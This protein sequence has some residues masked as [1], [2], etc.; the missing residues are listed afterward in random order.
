MEFRNCIDLLRGASELVDVT[1]PVSPQLEMAAII[2][3][4][5]AQ[6]NSCPALVFHSI[7]SSSFSCVANLFGTADR[8]SMILSSSDGINIAQRMS[9]LDDSVRSFD[10]FM[11]WLSTQDHFKPR[12][13][14]PPEMTLHEDF[15]AFAEIK[16][17]PHDA[18]HYL[19]L[20]V[21]ISQTRTGQQVNCGIYRVQ[22]HGP[23]QAT[24]HFRSG[25]DGHKIFS[26]Y[27]KHNESMPVTIILGCDP[28]LMF[29]AVF[30]LSK[31]INEFT[32]ASYIRQK[33][34]SY[35]CSELSS[36]P[37]PMHSEIVIQGSLDPFKTLA[38]GPFG[39]HE[40]YYGDSV[41]CP[42]FT[43]KRIESRQ[44]AVMPVTMIG[45][46]PTENM[47]LGSYI[48]QLI[49]PLVKRQIPQVLDVYMP[50]E[51]IFHGCAFVQLYV[52]EQLE[53][54]KEQVLSH[55]LFARSKLL[56][57]VD[58]QV[59]VDQPQ[60]L[61]WRVMN[62]YL[63]SDKKLN[64]GIPEQ[65]VIDTVSCL[66]QRLLPNVEIENMVSDRWHELG[67]ESLTRNKGS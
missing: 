27:Q 13:V 38:E 4:V 34:V 40:G 8:L 2:K 15:S 44:D 19:S 67:L 60:Q 17:W 57:F 37:I 25:S 20:A 46:P 36:L 29:A 3:R 10:S 55:P 6:S 50:S 62:H 12:R 64:Q 30:P 14:C 52:D 45:T 35:Y 66:K 21:V 54:V 39:N 47:V 49:I 33:P 32:F 7:S 9:Q 42:V 51:T 43:L 48:A 31:Q 65:V 5:V 63:H 16:V 1:V 53:R 61:M 28:A 58:D 59:D 56:V 24:I 23:H 18:G 26:E 11:R 22:I 41:Q